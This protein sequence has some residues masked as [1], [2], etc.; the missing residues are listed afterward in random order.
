MKNPSPKPQPK[1]DISQPRKVKFQARLP[2]GWNYN[3]KD[4]TLRPPVASHLNPNER[5]SNGAE[6]TLQ[7][8]AYMFDLNQNA[9][10]LTKVDASLPISAPVLDLNHKD[11]IHSGKEATKKSITPFFDLNQIS[12]IQLHLQCLNDESLTL[13]CFILVSRL[14]V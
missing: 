10:S 14:I 9:R 12:V 3:R 11:R 4:S 6:M 7:K 8:P 2:K 13:S 5:I 1:Q